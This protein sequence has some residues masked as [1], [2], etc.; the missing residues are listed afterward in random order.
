MLLI[1]KGMVEYGIIRKAE[2][3]FIMYVAG[4]IADGCVS[5]MRV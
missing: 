2:I 4:E 5:R 3:L 1:M